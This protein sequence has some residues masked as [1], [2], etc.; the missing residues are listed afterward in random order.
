MARRAGFTLV[1]LLVVIA[2][3]GILIALLLPAVQAAREAA[4]RASCKNN[5]KQIGLALQNYHAALNVLPPGV[6]GTSGR[7]SDNHLLHTWETLILPYMEQAN[8]HETYDFR[9]RFDHAGNAAAV[10]QLL[11]VYL[12]PTMKDELVDNQFGPSHYA[13]NAG[14]VPGQDDGVL[15]PM[16]RINFRDI[17]DGTSQTMAAGELAF[18]VGGWARGASNSGGGGGG[19]GGQGFARGVLRWWQCAA[20]CARPGLNPPATTCSGSCERQFQ[21]SSLHAGGG[22]FAFV[23]GHTDFFSDTTD[24]HLYRALLTRGA[25]EVV[26]Q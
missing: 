18:D 9:V 16:S 24:V 26:S 14:T 22:H 25:G 17:T 12:C 4:R 15:Y 5:L 20:S 10:I 21:F 7:T 23:D 19:G 13:G 1:E 2:I 6:L 3:I 8:L 11:P